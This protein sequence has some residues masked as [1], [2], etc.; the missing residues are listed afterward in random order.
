MG[1][2]SGNAARVLCR[3]GR[4]AAIAI[5]GTLTGFVGAS[6]R[7]QVVMRLMGAVLLAVGVFTLAGGH[8][9]LQAS[10]MSRRLCK[11][12]YRIDLKSFDLKMPPE[13]S[14]VAGVL[15][16][17]GRASRDFPNRLAKE[18]RTIGADS[19]VPLWR[20]TRL[21][22]AGLGDFWRLLDQ[23]FASNQVVLETACQT[24]QAGPVRIALGGAMN[25]GENMPQAPDAQFLGE[26]LAARTMRELHQGRQEL[27]WTHLI[28]TTRLATAW[29]AGPFEIEHLVRFACVEIAWQTTW[30]A[31]QAHCW[32]EEQMAGLQREWE[33]AS[34]RRNYLQSAALMRAAMLELCE[35]ARSEGPVSVAGPGFFAPAGSRIDYYLPRPLSLVADARN[36]VRGTLAP[37]WYRNHGFF[38]DQV[39]VMRHY[40]AKEDALRVALELPTWSQI[41]CVPGITN[42]LS[43]EAVEGREVVNSFNSHQITQTCI[44]RGTAPLGRLATAEAYR[45]LAIAALAIE[46]YRLIHGRYPENLPSLGGLVGGPLTDPMDGLPLR[47]RAFNDGTFLLYSVGLDCRDDG[48]RLDTSEVQPGL[49]RQTGDLVWPRQALPLCRYGRLAPVESEDGVGGS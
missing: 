27:A 44:S 17:A 31:L 1:S 38:T 26:A 29:E 6:K 20:L 22:H 12:G 45:Q 40:R 42:S 41:R 3:A 28:A 21:E 39:A 48:G 37:L 13:L 11:A 25:L 14:A 34:F 15:A 32:S 36:V 8:A 18:R 19:A 24:L 23:H 43:L 10:L 9:R 4:Q 16:D 35:R 30:S 47:Y 5:M 7:R 2:A 33:A 46:R 49:S